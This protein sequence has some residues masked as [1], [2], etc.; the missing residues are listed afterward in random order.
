MTTFQMYLLVFMCGIFMGYFLKMMFGQKKHYSGTI[1]VTQGEEKL[2]YSL[3]L[4]D[5]PDTIQFKKEVV[6]KVDA[7]KIRE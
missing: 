7:P 4:D 1:L 2:V 5:Y 3:E 6:F